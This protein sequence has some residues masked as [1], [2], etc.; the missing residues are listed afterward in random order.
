M[1][2]EQDTCNEEVDLDG[3]NNIQQEIPSQ[4]PVHDVEMLIWD[5]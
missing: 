4:S 5:D 3:S 2:Q 1:C